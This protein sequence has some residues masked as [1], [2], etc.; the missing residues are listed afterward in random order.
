MKPKKKNVKTNTRKIKV[1][2]QEAEDPKTSTKSTMTT[3]ADERHEI[4]K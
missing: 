3:K 1:L 4:A 2:Y